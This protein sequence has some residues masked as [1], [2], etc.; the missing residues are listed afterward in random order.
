[1]RR[2]KRLVLSGTVAVGALVPALTVAGSPLAVSAN[3]RAAA[4][5]VTRGEVGGHDAN[6]FTDVGEATGSRVPEVAGS[7]LAGYL[8]TSSPTSIQ[9]TMRVPPLFCPGSGSFETS[10]GVALQGPNETPVA[11]EIDRVYLSCE[12]GVPSYEGR[13]VYE[14]GASITSVPWTFTPRV[15]DE[16]EFKI[17][18]GVIFSAVVKDVTRRAKSSVSATCRACAGAA[19]D[20]SMESAPVPPFTKVNWTQVR[21]NSGTLAASHPTRYEEVNGSDVLIKTSRITGGGTAFMNRFVASS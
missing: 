10:A 7:T 14:M 16:L 5:F 2:T 17:T 8:T 4:P 15:G 9:A 19:A 18:S 6:T 1:M 21:V 3:A 11:L 20:V 12:N 13:F